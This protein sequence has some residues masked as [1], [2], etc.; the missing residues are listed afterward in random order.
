MLF[1]K[2]IVCDDPF[3]EINGYGS[4]CDKNRIIHLLNYF[5]AILRSIDNN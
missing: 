1:I 5:N 4:K 3:K 2:N